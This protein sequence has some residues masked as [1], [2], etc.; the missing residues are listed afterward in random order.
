MRTGRA[1]LAGNLHPVVD[2]VRHILKAE[3][4]RGTAGEFTLPR[5]DSRF[6]RRALGECEEGR[7]TDPVDPIAALGSPTHKIDRSQHSVNPAFFRNLQNILDSL[8]IH[9]LSL[10]GLVKIGFARTGELGL[11]FFQTFNYPSIA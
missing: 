1:V 4:E 7:I 2:R 6:L 8:S 9:A 11:M 5:S 10:S 3:L